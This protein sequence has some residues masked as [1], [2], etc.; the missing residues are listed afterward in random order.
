MNI[1]LFQ[2][3]IERANKADGSGY[4]DLAISAVRCGS[5]GQMLWQHALVHAMFWARL[6]AATL[7]DTANLISLADVLTAY[8]V[9]ARLRGSIEQADYIGAQAIYRLEQ[10]SQLGGE[11]AAAL[12]SAAADKLSPAAISMAKLWQTN[13]RSE[14]IVAED[15]CLAAA[16]KGDAHAIG[17]VFD[18]ALQTT[19]TAVLDAEDAVALLGIIATF[20]QATGDETLI[21]RYAGVLLM[22]AEYRGKVRRTDEDRWQQS[23]EALR[24]LATMADRNTVGAADYLKTAIAIVDPQ[25][26][27]IVAKERPDI[28]GSTNCAGAC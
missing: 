15:A 26:V 10:A 11:D 12:L 3:L 24:L 25:A 4:I 28:L 6:G 5:D 27:A 21:V 19:L 7:P 1:D 14:D 17:Q 22:L 13:G 20:G 23:A 8:A 16:A 9:D 2:S 18:A